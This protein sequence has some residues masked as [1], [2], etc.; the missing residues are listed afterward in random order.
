MT[1]DGDATDLFGVKYCTMHITYT[2]NKGD[3]GTDFHVVITGSCTKTGGWGL[4]LECCILT[5]L[6]ELTETFCTVS[7]LMC[8]S[9]VWG[10]E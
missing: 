2:L 8:M 3:F 10:Q 6:I 1:P 9:E 4:S 5:C 7:Q